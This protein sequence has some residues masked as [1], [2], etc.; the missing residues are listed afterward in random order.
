[1]SK[2]YQYL[3]IEDDPAFVEILK[4]IM[5]K[6]PEMKLIGIS[7]NTV[8]AAKRIDMDKPEVLLLD[9]NISGLEGPEVLE[10]SEH[11]PLTIV[12]SSHPEEVMDNYDV[13]YVAFIQKPLK[14]AEQ[15]VNAIHKCI[16]LI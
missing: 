16:N 3:I 4:V 2:E 14:N 11:K 8:D 5:A 9:I 13:E 15:L 1:M 6:V 7:D 10:I 12:I